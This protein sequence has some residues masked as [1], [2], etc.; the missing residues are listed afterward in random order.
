[1]HPS[2]KMQKLVQL[3]EICV[4]LITENNGHYAEVCPC[5]EFPTT[6]VLLALNTCAAEIDSFR[7]I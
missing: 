1:M 3:A 6:L 5:S 7:W 2:A 4:E